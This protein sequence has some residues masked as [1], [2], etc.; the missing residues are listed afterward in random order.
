MFL[1]IILFY[2]RASVWRG[3][4]Y[5]TEIIFHPVFALSQAIDIRLKDIGSYFVSKNYLYNQN[6]KLQAEVSFDDA[7]MS[8][9][10]SVVADNVSMKEILGRA[11]PKAKLVLSAILAKPNQSPYDTLL[12]DAGGIAG[13]KTGDTVFALGNVP[14]GRV[15][16]VYPNSAKV[17][18]FS[19]P[20]EQ[21]EAIISSGSSVKNPARNASGIAD[22]GEISV[23]LVGRGGGNFEMVVPQG[24]TLQQGDQV[25][26]PGINSYVLGIVQ[27]VISDPRDPF[28]KAILTSPINIEE[29]KFVEV[30]IPS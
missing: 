20:G 13:I 1:L 27:T 14:V 4:S 19:N 25:V 29:Q 15:G 16:D 8:N 21:V 23:Q 18:L 26:L 11:D 5:S 7:R 17:I 10:D 3:L 30:E 24:M 22:A 6:Q 28:T 9:Y 12:I 2:F